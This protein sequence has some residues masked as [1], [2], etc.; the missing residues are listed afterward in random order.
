ML[1]AI[2]TA[3]V[4]PFRGGQLDEPTFR[5][6]IDHLLASGSEGVVVAGTTGEASTLTDPERLRLVEIAVDQ[7]RGRGS[8]VAGTGSNDTA[9][10]VHMT[11]AAKAL[12]ADAAL[13]V[14]PYYNRPPRAGIVAHFAAV[15]SEGLPIVAYNIPGRTGLNM[16]PDLLAELAAIPAVVAVKQANED[17][18]QSRAIL[19][20]TDLLLY[21][22]NDDMLLPVLEMGGRGVISVASHLVGE[23]LQEILASTLRGD[24]ARARDVDGKLHDLYVA[25]FETTNPILIK[26]AL[27]QCGLIP[28]P[29]VRLPL[30]E[31]T[32]AERDRLTRALEACGVLGA[33]PA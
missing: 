3:I 16:A 5:A 21:A 18:S 1:G 8:V 14:T 7:S 11:R 31:A 22:G 26:S 17:L 23:R 9:H 29:E 28:S 12:G 20:E 2:L 24:I 10:S 32:A 4:T 30:V 19:A 27:A 13:V 33:S 6:L 25:L 15:A